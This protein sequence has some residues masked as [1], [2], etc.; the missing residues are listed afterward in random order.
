M[1]EWWASLDLYMQILWM[2]TL[3]ASLIFIIQT[4]LTFTGMDTDSGLDVPDG[5][6]DSSTD[7]GTFP[8]QK[9]FLIQYFLAI[10][11]ADCL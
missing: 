11:K 8:F 9:I 6:F 10:A 4:I 7:V 5:G 2:I 3:S 1:Q